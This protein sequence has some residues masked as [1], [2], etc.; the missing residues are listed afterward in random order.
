MEQ[1]SGCRRL[2]YILITPEHRAHA[3][4]CEEQTGD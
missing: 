2:Y 3:L 1:G 4:V